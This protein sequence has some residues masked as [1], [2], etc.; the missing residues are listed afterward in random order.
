MKAPPL[1]VILPAT[2]IEIVDGDTIRVETRILSTVRLLGCWARELKEPGGI[3][4]RDNLIR[5]ARGQHGRLHIPMGEGIKNISELLTLGRV[6]GDFWLDDAT[7]SLS[8]MQVRTKHASRRKGG[9]L[10][11]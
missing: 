1:G 8:E 4:S 5:A 3:E 10:G 9:Q 2:A 11:D 6:L 7:E